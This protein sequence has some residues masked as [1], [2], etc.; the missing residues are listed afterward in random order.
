MYAFSLRSQKT[1]SG[2]KPGH[3]ARGRQVP[4]NGASDRNRRQ[5]CQLEQCQ[6]KKKKE[7]TQMKPRNDTVVKKKQQKNRM[8]MSRQ[9]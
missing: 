1:T 3:R 9:R 6:K 8:E 4:Q 5:R 2:E 7:K